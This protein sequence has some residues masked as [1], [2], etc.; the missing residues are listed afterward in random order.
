MGKTVITGKGLGPIA[1]LREISKYRL[2]LL[3]MA[4]RD[5]RIKYAQTLLGLLLAVL[6]PL[7][8]LGIFTVL[9]EKL[10]KL[11][12]GTIPYPLFAYSGIIVWN[13]FANVLVQAG[14]S[15]HA[16]RDIIQSIYFPRIILPLSKGLSGLVETFI[17]MVFLFLLLAIYGI[18]P[19]WE[20]L[21][22]P[23]FMLL[24]LLAALGIGIWLSAMSLRFRDLMHT[25]PFVVGL[26]IWLTPIYYP[27]SLVPAEYK[28]LLGLNPI[29]GVLEGYRWTVLGGDL[30]LF[31]QSCSISIILLLFLSGWIAFT[32]SEKRIT[33]YI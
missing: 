15:L 20:M 8:L 6:Q 29:T 14:G 30:N 23:F 26:G 12:T 10:I 21:A 19:G 3:N 13:L 32:K 22:L 28:W 18:K 4:W 2:L 1:Y 24:N 9:F 7:V 27:V 25:V 16:S 31:N 33:D 17:Q 5:L 11:D